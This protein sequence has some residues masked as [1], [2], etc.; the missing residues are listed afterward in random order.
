M[1][2]LEYQNKNIA[3][4]FINSA[5]IQTTRQLDRARV[6]S[7][8]F[9][10]K[11]ELLRLIYCDR[12][13]RLGLNYLILCALYLAISLRFSIVL[14][15]LGPMLL[16]YPHLIASYRFLQNPKLNLKTGWD[17]TRIFQVFLILTLFSLAIRFLGPHL[18]PLPTLPY[19]T[20]EIVLSLT[21]FTILKTSLNSLR[22]FLPMALTFAVIGAVLTLSWK[23][24]LAFVGIALIFHNWV[25][26][27]HWIFSAKDAKNRWVALA[28]TLIFALI[29]IFIFLGFFDSWISIS[30][31]NFLSSQ[32]FEVRG[33]T[34]AP[35]S[36]EP[37]MWDRAVVLYAFGLSLHYFIWL[38]AIPQ[39]LDH[40]SVPNSFRQSLEKLKADCG[41]KTTVL[42][43]SGGFLALALWLF[44]SFAGR[45]YFGV[46]M[47]HGWLEFV[48][49][50][51][52]SSQMVQKKLFRI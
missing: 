33:W 13:L 15:V 12:A 47:L 48:V 6:A 23:S 22:A 27:G 24:P 52:A 3:T 10:L 37:I 45:I 29:H 30:Q 8:R 35:W 46:A 38:R 28:A 2:I 42:L 21:L 11:F 5:V 36:N 26:F 41:P 9:T 44:T 31:F 19:G 50:I 20:W 39:N 34:L 25:A 43:F 4:S 7:L 14:L 1:R 49:L 17:T 16:G 51:T 32:S 18:G 40:K